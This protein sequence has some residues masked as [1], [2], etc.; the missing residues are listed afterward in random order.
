VLFCD[1]VTKSIQALIGV[2][3]YHR[4]MQTDYNDSRGLVPMP[5][6]RGVQEALRLVPPDSGLAS[7]VAEG[8]DEDVEAVIRQMQQEMVEASQALEFERAALLRDQI[9]ELKS[10][11]IPSAKA[12]PKKV[13]YREVLKRQRKSR[14]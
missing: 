7:H 14:K 9:R 11:G 1:E 10:G 6:H 13:D 3:E 5:V 2:T 12:P 4:R 8:A